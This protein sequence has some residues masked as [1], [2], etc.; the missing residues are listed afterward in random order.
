MWSAILRGLGR[1]Q[2][3]CLQ[4]GLSRARQ[5][6]VL[7]V[8]GVGV[9]SQGPERWPIICFVQVGEMTSQIFRKEGGLVILCTVCTYEGL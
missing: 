7:A 2:G 4:L 5:G 8:D 1:G 6:A 3:L 9:P